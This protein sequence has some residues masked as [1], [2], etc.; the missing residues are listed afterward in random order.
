M[1]KAKEIRNV[2]LLA[3]EE[4][5]HLFVPNKGTVLQVSDEGEMLVLTNRRLIT[6]TEG[7]G[8]KET[9]MVPLQKVDGV[10]TK[11]TKQNSMPLFQGLSLILAGIL[12]SLVLSALGAGDIPATLLGGTIALLGLVFVGRSL[13]WR[14]RGEVTF[15]VGPRDFTFP[16]HT[17][18]AREQIFGV[19]HHYFQLLSG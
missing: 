16:Y 1:V 5:V 14:V 4:V 19:A 8:K 18:E 11:G 2:P 7:D 6:F 12:V 15:L 17:K 3:G 9:R 10:L 13:A